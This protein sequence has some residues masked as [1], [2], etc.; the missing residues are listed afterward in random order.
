MSFRDMITQRGSAPQQGLSGRFIRRLRAETIEASGTI[1]GPT[2]QTAATGQR[3]VL[4]NQYNG[5]LL[6]SD[7]VEPDY[8]AA[9]LIAD[10]LPDEYG[11]GNDGAVLSISAIP[12]AGTGS[13]ADPAVLLYT[14]GSDG[15]TPGSIHLNA[16]EEASV[17]GAVVISKGVI[18]TPAAYLFTSD[19]DRA[20]A[21]DDGVVAWP[22]NSGDG[23]CHLREDGIGTMIRF[24]YEG[25]ATDIRVAD[26]Q[27]IT[28]TALVYDGAT[29]QIGVDTSSARFKT[30][31]ETLGEGARFQPVRFTWTED[32][33][34]H[35]DVGFIA[36]E[37]GAVEQTAAS[38]DADGNAVSVRWQPIV[39]HLCARLY[40]LEDEVAELRNQLATV[41]DEGT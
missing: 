24:R 38:Y 12:I 10:F 6:Y 41:S 9:V 20:F 30:N 37:A 2:Y 28:G 15:A 26:L 18:D 16:G 27:G 40:A 36:E 34:G 8:G 13:D 35:A 4:T 11:A 33:G 7:G 22:R 19:G 25:G 21:I 31:V 39:A 32:M 3:V 29:D 17:D 1:T 14:R 5:V 23:Y